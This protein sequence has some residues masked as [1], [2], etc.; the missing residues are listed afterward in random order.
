MSVPT[1]DVAN[2]ISTGRVTAD[3]S[4]YIQHSFNRISPFVSAG[5]ANSIID[6]HFWTHPFTTLGSVAH[7]EGGTDLD[8]GRGV[9]IGESLYADVPFGQQKVF[10]K[11]VKRNT[12]GKA[13]GLAKHGVFET[14]SRTTGDASIDRDNGVSI[15]MDWAPRPIFGVEFG[16]SHSVKYAYDSFFCAVSVNLGRLVRVARHL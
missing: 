16:Y 3:W 15:W 14:Q 13:K 12:T 10:S 5:I 8:V 2:G 4:N 11:L 7:F 9:S 6:S 1:G